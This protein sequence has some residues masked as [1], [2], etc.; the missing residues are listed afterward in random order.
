MHMS[1]SANSRPHVERHFAT[2]RWSVILQAR[3]RAVVPA[4]AA[5]AELCQA[6]W[7][8]IYGFIRGRSGNA[9]EAQDLTQAFFERLLDKKFLAD[10]NPERGRFRS[11]LLAAVQHF[12]SNEGDK[13]RTGKRGGGITF[14]PL[15]WTEGESRYV[16]EPTDEMTAERF[17]ERQWA[18]TLLDRVLERLRAEF[19]VA[20]REEVFEA[21]AEFLASS[22]EHTGYAAA[23]EALGSSEQTARVAAHRLR[24]RYR[25]LLK[26]EIAQTTS[27][28]A[29]AEEELRCLFAALARG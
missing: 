14:E 5:L 21:L 12:L 23:A 3:N 27:T 4:Q 2:T 29:E 24:K 26:E 16:R 18:L 15:D 13:A 6:Y 28:P 25:R 8:P 1:S 10:V 17:F 11:F 22:G 19:V 20:D 7:L 9:E